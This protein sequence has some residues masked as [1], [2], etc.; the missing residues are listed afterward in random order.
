MSDKIDKE[1]DALLKQIN[2]D[3]LFRRHQSNEAKWNHIMFLL[4]EIRRDKYIRGPVGED[5]AELSITIRGIE[6][7]DNGG[8][9]G[10]RKSE[11]LKRWKDRAIGVACGIAIGVAVSLI[12]LWISGKAQ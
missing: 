2:N 10:S 5:E 6:F 1:K 7:R 4:N 11:S 12:T 8:Y 3:T 9:S